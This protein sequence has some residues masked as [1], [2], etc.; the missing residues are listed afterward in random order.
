MLRPRVPA[1]QERPC[2]TISGGRQNHTNHRARYY[3]RPPALAALAAGQDLPGQQLVRNGRGSLSG[4]QLK[5]T[6]LHHC[7][8]MNHWS[9]EHR[10]IFS[11]KASAV[12]NPSF[13]KVGRNLKSS[14]AKGL[15]QR[16]WNFLSLGSLVPR[17]VQCRLVANGTPTATT[18][19]IAPSSRSCHHSHYRQ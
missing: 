8:T 17:Q 16:R 7:P 15:I 12:K 3:W 18:G 19:W 4:R 2:P 1:G 14:S 5:N 13:D 11:L 9:G 6:E 10:I